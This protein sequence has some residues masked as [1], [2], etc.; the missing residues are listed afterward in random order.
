MTS[1]III[2]P[3]PRLSKSKIRHTQVESNKHLTAF[4][5]LPPQLVKAK[6]LLGF[7]FNRYK[8]LLGFIVFMVG[9]IQISI[10]VANK[11]TSSI[12]NSG[13]NFSSCYIDI[14]LKRPHERVYFSNYPTYFYIITGLNSSLVVYE[15]N[16]TNPGTHK[17]HII[18]FNNIASIS[19][20]CPDM[21]YKI[22]ASIESA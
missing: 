20:T 12:I 4:K 5:P 11:Q 14:Y 8:I 22:L 9:T 7:A 17:A 21:N 18:P 1:E 15:S 19:K 13:I 3:I 6:K 10:E 16:S 2:T